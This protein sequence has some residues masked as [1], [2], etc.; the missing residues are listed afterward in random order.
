[1]AKP[2]SRI[3]R[4]FFVLYMVVVHAALIWLLAERFLLPRLLPTA[5]LNTGLVRDPV[6]GP[7]VMPTTLPTELPQPSVE[8][9]AL[10]SPFP[11]IA[12]TVKIIIPVQGIA[13]EQL[14]DTFSEARSE[15]RSHD[16]MDIP[17]PAGTPVLAAVD[18]E[19]V[20]FFDSKLGGTTIYQITTDRKYFLYYAHLQRRAEGIS[21]KQ[22]VRQGTVIGYVGD[23]GNAGVGNYHLHFS[24]S[25]VS[26][27]NRFWEGTP[28]N[29][30]PILTGRADL[31]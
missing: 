13:A 18:G 8:P 14:I 11:T 9:S 17:A 12:R 10:P 24:I 2:A 31:W 23:T 7:Q 19:I 1:M 21:E 4:A 28:I 30:Y 26:D 25:T 16:A 15:G 5:D 20:K 6:A 3:R 22:F 27:P 29:P